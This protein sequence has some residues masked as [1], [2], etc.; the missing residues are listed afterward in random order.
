MLFQC[1]ILQVKRKCQDV[2]SCN[3]PPSYNV[4]D[5]KRMYELLSGVQLGWNHSYNF[6]ME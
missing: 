3:F 5:F 1:T 2:L 4:D 6:K